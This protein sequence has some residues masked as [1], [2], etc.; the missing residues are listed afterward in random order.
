MHV[1]QLIIM[2][3]FGRKKTVKEQMREN[4]KAL[5]KVGRT[6]DRDMRQL[7]RDENQLKQEIKKAA[8]E[9][10]KEAC[11][12]LAKQLVLL[13]KQKQ[14]SLHAKGTIQSIGMQS[15]AMATNMKLADAMGETTK[16]M[17]NIGKIMKP[18]KIAHDVKEFEKAAMRMGMT[19]EIDDE[20]E[21]DQIVNQV[22]DEIGI[23]LSGKLS[24]APTAPSGTPSASE[25]PSSE[26]LEEQLAKL[27][28]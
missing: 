19:E 28:S 22:L 24:K 14:R 15:K 23:E 8:K 6:M 18:E 27:R 1:L 20:E 4:D 16:T 2:N 3:F 7:E 26:E 10:N 25:L 9:G 5:R 17:T 11:T 21:S 13:R 12:V